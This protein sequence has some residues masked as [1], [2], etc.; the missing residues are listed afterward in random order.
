M[1]YPEINRETTTAT[2]YCFDPQT[3]EY[4]GEELADVD[5]FSKAVLLPPSSTEEEPPET[6][7]GKVAVFEDGA[8]EVKTD[9]RGK[10]YW[11][12]D[13][14]E[15]TISTIGDA[16]PSDALDAQPPPTTNELWAGLREKRD[17][18]LRGSDVKVLPDYPHADGAAKQ[19]WLDYRQ[20]LR[21]LPAGTEDP[22]APVWPTTPEGEAS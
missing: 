20:A 10:T 13:G 14:S 18:L 15:Y 22:A 7:D 4:L 1:A 6:Q 2:V 9:N 3:K 11:V 5:V 21:D 12:S 16:V 17:G 19:K 8:W